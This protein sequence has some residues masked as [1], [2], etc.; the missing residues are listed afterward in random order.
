MLELSLRL[1]DLVERNADKLTKRWLHDVK[2]HPGTRTYHAYDETQLY[3]R[4][5]RVYSH[6]GKWMSN[7]TTK[8]DIENLYTAL[9]RQ[10]RK[11]GYEL[12]EVIQAL[13]ITRRHVWLLVQYEGFMDTALELYQA[14]GLVNRAV[15]FFDR[16]IYFTAVGYEMED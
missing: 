5:Y 2:K 16:A 3:Q 13:I 7:E 14:L 15:L 4:A 1:V 12:S 11:E 6:F 9:G 10:R 8:E